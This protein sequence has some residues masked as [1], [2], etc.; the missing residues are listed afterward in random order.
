MNVHLP[1]AKK[2]SNTEKAGLVVT[3]CNCKTRLCRVI[4][5]TCKDSFFFFLVAKGFT[6]KP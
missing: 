6:T 3:A 1:L 5:G 4:I 2:T